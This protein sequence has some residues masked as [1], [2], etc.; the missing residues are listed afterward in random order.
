MK[1]EQ[2]QAIKIVKE[3]LNTLNVKDKNDF[4]LQ[5]QAI[6]IGMPIISQNDKEYYLELQAIVNNN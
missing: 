6:L 1:K 3:K 5:L 4:L 2:L